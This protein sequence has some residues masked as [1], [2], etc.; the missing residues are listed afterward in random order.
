MIQLKDK[1]KTVRVISVI[2]LLSGSMISFVQA[3]FSRVI[4]NSGVG[5]TDYFFLID[6]LRGSI[7][8]ALAAGG[9]L[10]GNKELASFSQLL[11]L[12]FLILVS[13][14]TGLLYAIG[15][16]FR[17]SFYKE[18]LEMVCAVL[19]LGILLGKGNTVRLCG[20][21]SMAFYFALIALAGLEHYHGM[22]FFQK[23]TLPPLMGDLIHYLPLAVGT[24][25]LAESISQDRNT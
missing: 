22:A 6:R 9:I 15:W 24:I 4:L 8:T 1:S 25:L 21:V 11:N 12:S 16:V 18:L 17:T 19:F 5:I 3:L 14:L 13:V 20:W 2:L 10:F 7:L 23:N